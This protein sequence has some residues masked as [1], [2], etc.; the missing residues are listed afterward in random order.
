[1]KQFGPNQLNVNHKDRWQPDETKERPYMEG[2]RDSE[3]HEFHH[4]R[5]LLLVLDTDGVRF[6][7][8]GM[9]LL[10]SRFP[11]LG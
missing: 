3:S 9:Y 8:Q 11:L 2:Q 5:R 7:S 6:I 10:S 1:L 4:G